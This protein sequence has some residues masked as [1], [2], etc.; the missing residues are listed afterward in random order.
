MLKSTLFSN[1]PFFLQAVLAN[2]TTLW[3]EDFF[4]LARNLGADQMNFTRLI[5]MGHAKNKEQYQFNLP[6]AGLKLKNAMQTILYASKKYKVYT[7]TSGPLWCLIDKKLGSMSDVGINAF[8]IDYQGNFKPASRLPIKFGNVLRK[9]MKNIFL[10]HSEMKKLRKGKDEICKSCK[11]YYQCRGD[12]C[13]NYCEFGNLFS[14]DTGCWIKE[15]VI[16]S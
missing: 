15:S 9:S 5:M 1:I 11:Y 7:S 12:R 2:K 4:K 8:V 14:M 10:N 16:H 3:I 13:V 6:I